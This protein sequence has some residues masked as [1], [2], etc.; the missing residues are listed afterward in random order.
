MSLHCKLVPIQYREYEIGLLAYVSCLH[1][2]Q[3]YTMCKVK[4]E[5][6]N[7]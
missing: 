7:G 2:S 3:I 5:M 1:I 4:K 6:Q